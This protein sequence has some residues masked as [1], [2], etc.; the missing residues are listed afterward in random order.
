L[1]FGPVSVLPEYQ[2]RGVG[3]ALI[4]HTKKL[5]HDKGYRAILIYGDPGYYKRFGFAASKTWRIT[6]RDGKYPAALLALELYPG[7]LNGIT[8]KFGEADVYEVDKHELAEFEKGFPPKVKG[9]S[10]TQE[11]FNELSRLFL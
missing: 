8:G 11:R 6:N 7:A 3:S 10:K 4:E 9:A 1:T 2:N 5:A